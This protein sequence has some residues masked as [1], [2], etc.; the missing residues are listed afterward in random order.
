MAARGRTGGRVREGT[1]LSNSPHACLPSCMYSVW[2][3][4]VGS[5]GPSGESGWRKGGGSAAQGQC[6]SSLLPS[7]PLAPPS[8]L[9]PSSVS[10]PSFLLLLL[11]RPYLSSKPCKRVGPPA[12]A[13]LTQPSTPVERGDTTRVASPLSS[14][15]T[16]D[17][18]NVSPNLSRAQVQRALTSVWR[19]W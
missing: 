16:G 13:R 12:P 1:G 9:L 4:W 3:G 8:P 11:L 14:R 15:C 18:P 6:A 5:D 17:N 2:G 10:T 7:F 19:H